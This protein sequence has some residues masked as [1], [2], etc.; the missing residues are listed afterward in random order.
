MAMSSDGR[1]LIGLLVPLHEEYQYLTE[2]APPLRTLEVEGDFYYE[3]LPHGYEQPIVVQVLEEMGSLRSAVA[4]ERMLLRFNPS[5]IAL[6]GIAGALGNEPRLGDVVVASEVEYYQYAT[7]VVPGEAPGS[8]HFQRGGTTW[9]AED[10]LIRRIQSFRT[11]PETKEAFE[12][13][14][15]LTSTRR[16]PSKGLEDL[17]RSR[18]EYFV[19]PLASGD[20]VV[21]A[22]AMGSWLLEHNRKLVAVEMEAAGVAAAVASRHSAQGWLV[23]RGISDFANPAKTLLD[24]QTPTINKPAGAWRRYAVLSAGE[25]L[26]RLIPGLQ[27]RYDPED[28]PHQASVGSSDTEAPQSDDYEIETALASRYGDKTAARRL[29]SHAGIDVSLIRLDGSPREMWF[30]AILAVR[31]QTALDRLLRAALRDYPD[32]SVFKRSL[33][34]N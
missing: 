7:K 24:A 28:A 14:R 4:A 6:L 26:L 33:G 19:A 18:P 34:P 12:A 21:A 29:L 15:D 9:R 13:W 31:S 8:I 22:Q 3:L 11:R 25:F 10:S 27:S 32:I 5:T 16:P 23:V 17:V 1:Y 2:L 20:V 30:E